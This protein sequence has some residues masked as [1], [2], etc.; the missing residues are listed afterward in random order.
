M[1]EVPAAEPAVAD[2]RSRY[3]ATSSLG[4]PAHITV[5]FPFMS[6]DE[7][8]SDVLREAQGALTAVKPFEFSLTKVGRFPVTSYLCP[9]PPEPFNALTNALV[10][11]FPMFR[12]Y[13]G[14]HGD[15]VPHLT[16]AHGDSERADSAAV[17]LERRLSML[18]PIRTWCS[19][20][21][22]LE[23]SSGR[24]KRMH[25]I[26]LGARNVHTLG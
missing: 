4:V 25:V 3:D 10:G 1:V 23:N 7:I 2:L 20:V 13:G 26:E 5:L 14:A 24:W 8:T 17:E 12:P 21:T 16:V 9:E 11:R 18:D 15:I 19:A 22:L 6:P